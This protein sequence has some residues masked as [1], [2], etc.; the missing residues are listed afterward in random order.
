MICIINLVKMVLV[1]IYTGIL[2]LEKY[3][4]HK[5]TKVNGKKLIRSLIGKD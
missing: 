1:K 3:L 2:T 4:N 5:N